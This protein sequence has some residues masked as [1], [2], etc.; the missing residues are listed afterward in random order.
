MVLKKKNF[1]YKSG[2]YILLNI[3]SVS[4]MSH[5]FSIASNP[6][7]YNDGTFVLYI[8]DLGKWTH[9]L[10]ELISNN[11]SSED[12]IDEDNNSNTLLPNTSLINHHNRVSLIGIKDLGSKYV[13]IYGPYG[14]PSID[15]YIYIS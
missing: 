11:H 10:N 3:P 12:D 8:K 1:K 6:I 13:K 7:K 14:Y 4:I 5:P 2:Q 9:H 15:V